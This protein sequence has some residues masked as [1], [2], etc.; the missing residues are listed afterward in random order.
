MA[1]D[2]KKKKEEVEIILSK[3]GENDIKVNCPENIKLTL[4]QTYMVLRFD[5]PALNVTPKDWKGMGITVL[6]FIVFVG[7][8]ATGV[9][10]IPAI[11]LLI[12]NF[13]INMNYYKIFIKKKLKEGYTVSTEQ[14]SILTDAGIQLPELNPVEA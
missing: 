3:E 4:F 2:K 1:N 11:L 8:A 14:E 6:L 13:W 10:I 7:L 9:A 5:F 12:V